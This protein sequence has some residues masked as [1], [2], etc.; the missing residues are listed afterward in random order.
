VGGRVPANVRITRFIPY[1]ELFGHASVFVTNGG[2]SGVTLALAHGIPLVQAGR[3]EEKAEIAARIRWSGVGVTLGTT[4]PSARAVADG[5]ARV[6]AEPSYRVAA[7]RI[8]DEMAPHDAGREGAALL[9]RIARTGRPVLRH[10]S[11]L[12]A[13]GSVR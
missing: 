2:Y 11:D 13:G 4:R 12:L 7:E 6:L 1:G 5:V 10:G 8:R 3:T 9:E